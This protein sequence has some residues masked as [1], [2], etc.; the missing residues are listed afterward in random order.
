MS[1][2]QTIIKH[3]DLVY[4]V[5]LHKGEDTYFYLKK[6]FRVVAFEADPDLAGQCRD[7]FSNEI[8][9]GKLTIVEGAIVAPS[10]GDAKNGTIKFFKNKDNSYWGTVESDRAVHNEHMGT[11]TEVIEVPVVDFSKC[12][13]EYGIPHYAKIDIEGAGIECLKALKHFKQKPDYVSIESDKLSFDKLLEELDLLSELGYSR[14]KASQQA[15]VASQVEPKSSKEGRYTGHQFQNGSSGLFGSDLPGEWKD[16]KKIQAEYKCIFVQYE[17]FGD[18]GT[19][20]KYLAGKLLREII[21]LIT[22]KPIPGYYDTHAQHS[23][24]VSK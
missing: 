5:G 13:K 23:S 22:Q 2:T 21:K 18:F 10:S 7:K 1:E 12:L 20:R 19:W 4:D 17:R 8:K 14:F 11:S 9:N 6:G 24:I 16:Y 3:E 15:S